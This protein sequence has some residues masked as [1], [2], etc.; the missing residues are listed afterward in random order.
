MDDD[1]AAIGWTC[2]NRLAWQCADVLCVVWMRNGDPGVV[3]TVAL[4]VGLA[5][6]GQQQQQMTTTL[7]LQYCTQSID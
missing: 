5:L 3:M 4:T 7:L 2:G 1:L 6:E